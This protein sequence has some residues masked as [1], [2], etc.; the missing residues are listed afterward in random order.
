M[1]KERVF[2]QDFLFESMPVNDDEYP[3]VNVVYVAGDVDVSS[4]VCV[5]LD[6]LLRL[7]K[8][9]EWESL[10]ESVQNKDVYIIDDVKLENVELNK[11][12]KFYLQ[13][14]YYNLS[15]CCNNCY[16]KVQ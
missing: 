8:L 7:N 4:A 11:Y 13:T 6:S 16:V 3:D 10:F 2:F 12:K 5:S 15:Q 9:D 1:A 14:F